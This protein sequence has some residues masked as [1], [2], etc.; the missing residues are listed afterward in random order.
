L[1][2]RRILGPVN[3][4]DTVRRPN[5]AQRRRRRHTEAAPRGH[6]GG[7][8]RGHPTAASAD[9]MPVGMPPRDAFTIESA[10]EHTPSRRPRLLGAG[11]H[12][13]GSSACARRRRLRCAASRSN[14]PRVCAYRKYVRA[15]ACTFFEPELQTLEVP[16]LN[17]WPPV[18]S[19]TI[20]R[21][22]N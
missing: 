16:G 13:A 5:F 8:A 19:G 4:A 21:A 2:G 14:A 12:R 6:G 18:S 10:G 7:G 1:D 22:V 15:C 17:I 11:N 9:S 3:S 20:Q